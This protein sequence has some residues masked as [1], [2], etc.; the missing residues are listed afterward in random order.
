[1]YLFAC[2][3]TVLILFYLTGCISGEPPQPVI[4][5]VTPNPFPGSGNSSNNAMQITLNNFDVAD[6]NL[7]IIIGNFSVIGYGNYISNSTGQ[8]SS[9]TASIPPYDPS[10]NT[11]SNIPMNIYALNN[12]FIFSTTISYDP[13]ITSIDVITSSNPIQLL[14]N[15]LFTNVTDN[16]LSAYITSTNGAAVFIIN[17]ISV[18]SINK[19]LIIGTTNISATYSATITFNNNSTNTVKFSV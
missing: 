17:T 14:V 8:H 15:G 16:N 5:N 10:L 11:I 6:N 9:I 4:E 3:G 19:I 1:M 13:I 12:G 18:N 2:I 7:T